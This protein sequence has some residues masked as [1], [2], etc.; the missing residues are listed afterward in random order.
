M[1]KA[2]VVLWKELRRKIL[3]FKFRRQFGVGPYILDFYCP[4]LKFCIELDGDVHAIESTRVKDAIRDSFL[5]KC[6]ITVKRYWNNDVFS[7]VDSVLED[8]YNTCSELSALPPK[9]KSEIRE[10]PPKT[11]GRLQR[12]LN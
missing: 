5:N 6:G 1:T 7:N 4:Q 2:E 10:S 12:G 3:G 8:I 11:R 9:V